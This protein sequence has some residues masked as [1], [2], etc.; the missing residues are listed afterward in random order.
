MPEREKSQETGSA[1]NVGNVASEEE[2][3]PIFRRKIGAA[4]RRVTSFGHVF[5]RALETQDFQQISGNKLPCRGR[6]FRR[7]DWPIP[8]S[9]AIATVFS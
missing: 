3:S 9:L 4:L 7:N 1:E 8:V 6:W 2:G 5:R